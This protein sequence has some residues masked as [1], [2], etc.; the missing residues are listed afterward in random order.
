MI[1]N[2]SGIISICL[3]VGVLI[4]LYFG[5]EGCPGTDEHV[6]PFL[7]GSLFAQIAVLLVATIIDNII[8]SISLRGS[9]INNLHKR[10]WLPFWLFVRIG[11][12][13]VE[14]I[15]IIICMVAIFGPAPYAAG[16]FECSEFHDGPLLFARAVVIILTSTF[17]IY[18][19]I[20]AIYLDPCGLLCSPSL[21]QDLE[22]I[23]KSSKSQSVP[24]CEHTEY[25]KDTLLG[26]LH[27]SHLGYGRI[28]RKLNGLFCCCVKSHSHVIA[29]REMALAFHTIFSDLDRV[30]FDLVAGLKLLG[31][32]QQN[33]QKKCLAEN[34]I[35]G[36]YLHREF[37]QV[38]LMLGLKKCL[39]SFLL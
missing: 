23:L 20:Y 12:T 31:R 16:Q 26:Q 33:I 8:F 6:P 13:A 11:F 2:N 32:Y 39:Y 15:C 10:K 3:T 24:E 5:P 25:A 28:F 37:R 19:I 22:E 38:C 34:D 1:I 21:Q 14:L 36:Y 7:Y 4:Y 30:P 9:I 18:F 27:T 17:V 29:L 35:E